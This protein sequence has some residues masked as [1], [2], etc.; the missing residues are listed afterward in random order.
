[1]RTQF[2]TDNRIALGVMIAMP[3]ILAIAIPLYFSGN[4]S[5]RASPAAPGEARVQVP[6]SNGVAQSAPF[7]PT[8]INT[9]TPTAA[10]EP[11]T[12]AP[13][14]TYE[15]A[16]VTAIDALLAERNGVYGLVLANPETGSRYS[17][18]ADVPF[19]AASLY[20]LVLLADVYAAIDDGL[21]AADAELVLQ[22]EYF[23]GPDEPVDSYYDVATAGSIVPISDLLYATGAYSSNVAAY[24]L[25]AL[26]DDEQLESMARRLGMNDTY[27]HVQPA[28]LDTWPP[29]DLGDADPDAFAEAVAFAEEQAKDGPLML[30]TARDIEI[31]FAELLA[32]EVV[33]PDVS[34]LILQILKDQAVDDRFPCLLPFETEIAHKTGNLDHVVHDVGIIWT[35][36]GPVIL[37]AMI[38]DPADD[39]EATL[40]IQRLAAIAYGLQP[41]PSIADAFATPEISCGIVEPLESETTESEVTEVG[42]Y[43]EPSESE[44]V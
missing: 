22:P 38:E 29:A 31:Y 24:A 28:E 20:K 14:A 30:T 1:M 27:F 34:A 12:P 36:E 5:L 18:N 17:R 32:G 4:P 44:F 10:T 43:G 33:N 16:V 6:E 7:D 23:P 40:V 26:T 37:V 25:L 3:I 13:G 8:G 41:V 21:I 39:A 9:V 15:P 35:D 42:A 2:R 19:L 11:E